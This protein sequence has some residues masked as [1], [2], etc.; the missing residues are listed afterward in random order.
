ML[1]PVPSSEPKQLPWYH[2]HEA[3]VP[4]LPPFTDNVEDCPL[5]I[6]VVAL[7]EIAGAEVSLTTKVKV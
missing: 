6:G 7:A 2:F 3:P 5:H 4:S 1:D